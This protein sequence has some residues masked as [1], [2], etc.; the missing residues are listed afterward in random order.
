MADRD[1][2]NVNA[3]VQFHNALPYNIIGMW[4]NWSATSFGARNHCEFESRHP[5][6]NY[7]KSLM[8]L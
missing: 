8:I 4:A 2:L 5:D 1:A 7:L 3:V 6:H